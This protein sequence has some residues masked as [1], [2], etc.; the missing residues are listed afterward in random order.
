MHDFIPSNTGGGGHRITL[1]RTHNSVHSVKN[2]TPGNKEK[3]PTG[4]SLKPVKRVNDSQTLSS[5][6]HI[7]VVWIFLAPCRPLPSQAE[8]MEKMG[9][10]QA[11]SGTT[12]IHPHQLPPLSGSPG[13]GRFHQN[14]E[15]LPNSSLLGFCLQGRPH[16]GRQG[17]PGARRGWRW[18]CYT[19]LRGQGAEGSSG[20]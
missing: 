14:G 18:M 4:S 16:G 20:L 2:S 9:S 7:S 3:T 6:N 10:L 15:P 11:S 19:E 12:C 17:C 13:Y 8:D 5:S 1:K